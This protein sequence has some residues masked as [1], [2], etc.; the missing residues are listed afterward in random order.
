MH[1]KN[2][3]LRWSLGVVNW[4]VQRKL[5]Q[6]S[7]GF[8]TL[9]RWLFCCQAY[10][11][12]TACVL[13]CHLHVRIGEHVNIG[14][15]TMC[16][17]LNFSWIHLDSRIHSIFGHV[18]T[19]FRTMIWS[20]WNW[21]LWSA[22][23]NLL[24]HRTIDDNRS[25]FVNTWWRIRHDVWSV[26]NRRSCNILFCSQ[27]SKQRNNFFDQSL[28]SICLIYFIQSFFC[29]FWWHECLVSSLENGL[30]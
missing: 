13:S 10:S 20:Q 5:S 29:V 26:C 22:R 4:I 25:L 1:W 2:W 28:N 8:I 14:P 11:Q 6:S 15:R 21:M 23:M 9:F 17:I 27:H 16:N 12:V 7:A 19:D 18:T 24:L 30:K 3:S